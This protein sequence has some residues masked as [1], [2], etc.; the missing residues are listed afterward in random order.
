MIF[1]L[2]SRNAKTMCLRFH[3]K[4]SCVQREGG[5]ERKDK[6]GDGD[7]VAI[8]WATLSSRESLSLEHAAH[9]DRD[10]VKKCP[11]KAQSQNSPLLGENLPDP[12]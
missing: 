3:E 8:I 1:F 10:S 6:S 9:R 11:I 12:G 5:E 4:H 2:F 7:T